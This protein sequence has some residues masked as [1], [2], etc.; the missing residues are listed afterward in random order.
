LEQALLCY[1]AVLDQ[2]SRNRRAL[3]AIESI[4][5]R[6][7]DWRKL[8]DTYEKM[9]DVADDDIEMADIYSRMARLCSDALDEEEKAIEL[10]GRVLEIR[11]EEPAALAILADLTTRQNKWEE[12]VEIVE[13]QIAVAP[14]SDQIPLYKRLGQVWEDKLGRE[15]NAL[16]AW[17]A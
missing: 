12:L 13:R 15:R 8:F 17:L 6:R 5:F 2:E 4:H 3:E 16:D 11:G 10:L 14:D 9:I 1:T 7:E